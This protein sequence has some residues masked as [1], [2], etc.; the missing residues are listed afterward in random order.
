MLGQGTPPIACAFGVMQLRAKSI[1]LGVQ[2][3]CVDSKLDALVLNLGKLLTQL[4]ILQ[5]DG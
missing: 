5:S 3:A 1:D 2:F 4:S